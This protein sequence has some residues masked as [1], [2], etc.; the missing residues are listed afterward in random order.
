MVASLPYWVGFEPTESL[1]VV[2]CHEPRGRVGLSMRFDLPAGGPGHDGPRRDLVH[3]VAARVRH[4]R[5]SRVVLA[6]YTDEGD[7]P[8]GRPRQGLIDALSCALSELVVTEAVL[9]RGGRFWSYLCERPSCCP[10]RG[11]PVE[12]G[13]ASAPV[14]LL[15]AESVLSGRAVLPDRA[16]VVASLAAPP[17]PT[18]AAARL[19]CRRCEDVLASSVLADGVQDTREASRSAWLDAVGRFRVPPGALD[20]VEAAALAV[21]LVD[22]VVRDGVL[23]LWREDDCGLPLLLTELCRRTPPPYDAPVCTVLA[24]VS[25]AAGGGALVGVSLDRALATDPD[26]P[27]A[28]LLAEALVRQVSPRS[29]RDALQSSRPAGP[30]PNTWT[31]RDR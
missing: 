24:W 25:Y 10:P 30:A 31:G 13:S 11:R 18:A 22:V 14:R 4:E 12:A 29:M 19:R 28:L 3:Q 15:Q 2:C 26:Y 21:S 1:V 20:D 17:L 27:L 16:A 9:V 23:G 6:V 7:G 5:A 8:A